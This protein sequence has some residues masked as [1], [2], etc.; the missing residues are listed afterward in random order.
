[1]TEKDILLREELE[2]LQ[3]KHPKHFEIVFV[4]DNPGEGWKGPT[5]FIS[6]DLIKKHIS[7]PNLQGKVKILICGTQHIRHSLSPFISVL[8]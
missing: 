3:K 8:I 6:A 7:P 1:M 2:A 5:G 4:L